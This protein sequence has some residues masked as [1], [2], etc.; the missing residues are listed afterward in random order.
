[1]LR[2]KYAQAQ[3]HRYVIA[4]HL[5]GR[6]LMPVLDAVLSRVSEAQERFKR[7]CIAFADLCCAKSKT[8]TGCCETA[9]QG[10]DGSSIPILERHTGPYDADR[11]HD[12]LVAGKNEKS[13]IKESEDDVTEEIVLEVIGMDCPDCLSKVTR[14]VQALS[15]TKVK[16]ADG[17]R[18]LVSLS[19][20]PRKIPLS[21]WSWAKADEQD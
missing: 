12:G 17:V 21:S 4:I 20:D 9:C 18:G 16:N 6:A 1:M 10:E 3:S 19:Y 8:E 5:L 14:A 11:S 15:G 2:G 7:C 13:E